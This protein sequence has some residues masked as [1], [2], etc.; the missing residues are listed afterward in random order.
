MIG[1]PNKQKLLLEKSRNFK[2]LYYIQV[3]WSKKSMNQQKKIFL[4]H[5]KHIYEHI[6]VIDCSKFG[7][8]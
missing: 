8:S 4:T 6:L 1:H 3:F 5:Q 2:E 7:P